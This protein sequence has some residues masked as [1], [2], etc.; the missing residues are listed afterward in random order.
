MWARLDLPNVDQV[1]KKALMGALLAVIALVSPATAEPARLELSPPTGRYPVGLDTLHLVDSSRV[2][3]WAGG[4]RE[5][6]VSVHYPALARLGQRAPYLS[7][8]EAKAVI[9]I[10]G[11]A[12]IDPAVVAATRRHARVD[13]VPVP[14]RFPLVV[15]SPG[16]TLPR[17]TLSALAE[18]VTSQGYVVAVVDHAHE[19]A[20]ITY[21]DGRVQPCLACDAVK[22]GKFAAVAE[23]R[24][25]DV[26]FVLD[27]LRSWRHARVIDRSR[28]GMAGHSIG[29]NAAAETMRTDR[30]VLVGANL[31]GT[32][33]A[34]VTG[35]DRPF[36]LVG[37]DEHTPAATED[38]TWPRAWQVLTG[39]RRW[40]T[41]PRAGHLSFT[42]F[43]LLGEQLGL[44]GDP[45]LSGT[46]SVEIT[47]G[48]LVAFLDRHLKDRPVTQP[49]YPE[50]QEWR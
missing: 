32:F 50:I 25:A 33:F 14:R 48:L 34:P 45:E 28:I 29:G 5:L 43:P 49:V 35:L 26:S 23:G 42:D 47:R 1:I 40:V 39:P 18:E 4:P 8:A 30:R 44:P 22:E 24:A 20:A 13:A 27:R 11:H 9:E 21:P 17:A 16:F 31:D 6:M 2:D 12:G 3:Q 19:A 36:L 10:Q 37:T 7:E 46:R 41:L 38:P 15:L